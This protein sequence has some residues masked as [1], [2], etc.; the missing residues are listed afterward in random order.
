[1]PSLLRVV[2]P[3]DRRSVTIAYDDVRPN[4]PVE[5]SFSLPDQVERIYR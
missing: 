3:K 4:E 5:C 1:M 2:F